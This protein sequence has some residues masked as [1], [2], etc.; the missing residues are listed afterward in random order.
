MMKQILCL[1]ELVGISLP[2]NNLIKKEI[3]LGLVP[4]CFSSL[5]INHHL[6]GGL[7]IIIIF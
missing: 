3:V 1:V 7:V 5:W 2:S 6:L 4:V